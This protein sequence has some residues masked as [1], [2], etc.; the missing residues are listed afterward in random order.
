M[1]PSSFWTVKYIQPL[2]INNVLI[3]FGILLY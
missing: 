2:I 1:K 3:M